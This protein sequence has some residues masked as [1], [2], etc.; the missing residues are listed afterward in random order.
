MCRNGMWAIGFG[1]ISYSA[2]RNLQGQLP[3]G[4]PLI[5][6]AAKTVVDAT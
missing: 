6:G 4:V 5:S 3:D 1:T 2:A